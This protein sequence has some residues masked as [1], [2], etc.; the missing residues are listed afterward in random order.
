MSFV[1]GNELKLIHIE[2]LSFF[3]VNSVFVLSNACNPRNLYQC[4]VEK[5]KSKCISSIFTQKSNVLFLREKIFYACIQ[6][7]L[8]KSQSMHKLSSLGKPLFKYS[9]PYIQ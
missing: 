7:I 1:K 2:L 8:S 4:S 6:T 3:I 9:I 5:H